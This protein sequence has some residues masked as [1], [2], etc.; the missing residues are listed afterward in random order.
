MQWVAQRNKGGARRAEDIR[1]VTYCGAL[2][3]HA[4]VIW[5]RDS[6]LHRA[7]MAAMVS[8]VSEINN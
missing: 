3:P 7:G 1:G 4:L 5:L 6:N 2:G 8:S